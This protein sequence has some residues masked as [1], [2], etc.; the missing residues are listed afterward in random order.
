MR[1]FT[2]TE[3]LLMELLIEAN[4][5]KE[6]CIGI[7]LFMRTE[8]QRKMMITYLTKNPKAKLND[9][10]KEMVKIRKVIPENSQEP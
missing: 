10:A 1:E 6:D 3:R 9:I 7:C 5:T 8:D 2:E 4:L